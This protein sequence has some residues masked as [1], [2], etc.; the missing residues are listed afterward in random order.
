VKWLDW[1]NQEIGRVDKVFYL[2]RAYNWTVFYRFASLVT[3]N[4]NASMRDS[5]F[6]LGGSFET[7]RL[8]STANVNW[9]INSTPV[10]KAWIVN[11][12]K[13]SVPYRCDVGEQFKI[14][15]WA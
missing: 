4:P 13:C 1:N 6:M 8:G 12:P 14:D 3:N 10:T 5:T 7:A 9:G 15:H 2:S 11:A